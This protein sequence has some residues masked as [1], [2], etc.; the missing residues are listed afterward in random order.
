MN[1]VQRCARLVFVM[2]VFAA[3]AL[4]QVA[5]SL[6]A[7]GD[8]A[9]LGSTVTNTGPSYVTGSLGSGSA[10][11]GLAPA[12]VTGALHA[13]DGVA[14]GAQSDTAAAFLELAGRA[15]D[16][17]Y[18]QVTELGGQTL[19][20]GVYCFSSSAQLTGTLTLDGAGN[21]D[22]VW[23][24]KTASTL[25]TASNA[26]V[27]LIGGA[28][29]CNVFWQVGSSAT[30]GTGTSFA[31][32]ILAL[33]SITLATNANL[34]GRA[35][36]RHG[37]VTLDSN[38]VSLATCGMHP[39]SVV[40]PTLAETFFP[41]SV[42]TGTVSAMTI[43]LSNPGPFAAALT[44]PL[45]DVLP[46]GLSVTGLASTTCGGV[47]TTSSSMLTL[48]GGAIPSRGSCSVTMPVS[49]RAAG[50][51]FNSI[52]AGALQTTQGSN[53]NPAAA[54]LTVVAPVIISAPT[55]TEVFGLSSI[56][57]GGTS[58][59]T[60]TLTNP[61]GTEAQ[62]LA[63]FTDL[64][65]GGLSIS[66]AGRTTC[67]GTVTVSSGGSTVRLTGGAI[68]ASSSC[69][70]SVNVTAAHHGSYTNK[71]G[72]GALKT[73]QGTNELEAQATLTVH[74]STT[75]PSLRNVFSP[76]TIT[77]G[78]SALLTITLGNPNSIPAKLTSNFT[79]IL[80]NGLVVSGAASTTCGGTLTAALN[81]WR[82]ILNGGSI[83]ARGWCTVTVEVAAVPRHGA[84][85]NKLPSG[86]LKTELGDSLAPATATLTVRRAG[87]FR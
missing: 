53:V 29:S 79:D 51:Y 14:L 60:I 82:V 16:T 76:T 69:T 77:S 24:F 75:A 35:L 57:A 52:S 4:A 7:A 17:T 43:T 15:C 36:A 23:V 5:P 45:V 70:V 59:L 21:P 73:D 58:L 39:G 12:T 47:V 6:G 64:L 9:V 55:I 80:P 40:R 68:P 66:G 22:A 83:P 31:G 46:T 71:L 41:G 42:A 28:Q 8:F 19:G 50:P 37:A 10:I 54:I 86:A 87:A 11:T 38:T 84:F 78:Q 25:V 26:N 65:P 30:L 27:L 1:S 49:A 85:H 74:R 48:T 32:N 67:G 81:S 18:A 62:L 44:V 3:H 2:S 61:N 33:A 20:P 63:P 72:V 56:A 34:S 13:A